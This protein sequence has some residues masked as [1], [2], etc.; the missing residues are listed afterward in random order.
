MRMITRGRWI[1]A[2]FLAFANMTVWCSIAADHITIPLT[3]PAR[4]ATVK[5]NLYTGSVLVSGY[6]GNEV[7][8]D[9]KARGENVRRNPERQKPANSTEMKKLSGPLTDLNI[10]EEDNVVD[11]V[12]NARLSPSQVAIQVPFKSN[13]VIKIARHG[14]I[15]VDHVQGEIEITSS[16]GGVTLSQISG[17]V[18]SHAR[19][20]NMK[21]S[22][23]DVARG[24]PMSFSSMNGVIDVSLPSAIK[25][26]VS[27]QSVKGA[28]YSD[29]DVKVDSTAT[30]PVE[31]GTRG[32]GPRLFKKYRTVTGTLNGGG[33][34][35]QFKTYNG[36]IYVRKYAK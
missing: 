30:Q 34:E 19:Q 33:P 12:S 17:S 18:V 29:F 32:R 27:M 31:A 36:N 26:N 20:G 25:A 23:V 4:G 15:S 11:I 1:I 16:G 8:V 9:V 10:R 22:L 24:K 5:V 6:S 21:V 2:L 13:I 7:I 3:N 14:N 35:I 28:I